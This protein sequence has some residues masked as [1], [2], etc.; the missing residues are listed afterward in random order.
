MTG[1]LLRRGFV[2]SCLMLLLVGA[3]A[4][5]QERQDPLDTVIG[6]PIASV[7]ITVEG[8]PDASTSLLLPL[9]D[10]KPNDALTVE[11][12]RRVE[13]RFNQVPRF[14]SISV[15]VDPRPGGLVLIF[16]LIPRHPVDALLVP[17][18]DD[19]GLPP[20]EIERRIRAEFNGIPALARRGDVE[21]T[22]KRI[23]REE[24][25][26]D[27]DAQASVV[28]RHN[29]D[30]STLEVRVVAGPRTT[31]ADAE[32]EGQ[33]PLDIARTRVRMGVTTG[34]P[35]RKAEIEKTLA[36]IRAELRTKKYYSAIAQLLD[37]QYSADGKTVTLVITIDAGPLVE[38]HVNGELPGRQDDLIPIKREASVDR[39]LLEDSARGIE[40]EWRKQGYRHAAAAFTDEHPSPDLQVITF[41]ITK[42]KRYHVDHVDLPKDDPL[43]NPVDFQTPKALQPGTLFDEKNV[44]AALSAIVRAYQAKG[45]PRVKM[46]R[47]FDEVPLA[48][49][50][51]EGIIIRPHLVEGPRAFVRKIDFQIQPGPGLQVPGVPKE[52]LQQLMK[53]KENQPYSLP[54]LDWD[55]SALPVF[56]VNQGYL[57]AKVSIRP[58]TSEDGT[59]VTLVVQAQEGPQVLVKEI[60]VV[61]NEKV[62]TET[63]M[64]QV[65]LQVGQPYSESKR[66]ETQ[67]ALYRTQQ[68]R[69]VRVTR[70]D[71]IPGEPSA[72]IVVAVEEAATKAYEFG[73]G[74]E[75]G[76]YPV[77]LS[78]GNLGDRTIFSP[79]GSVG[80]A[81]S[82]IGGRDR[83]F[84]AFAR[85]SLK[86]TTTQQTGTITPDYRTI[87]TYRERYAFHMKSDFLVSAVAEQGL[88]TTYNFIKRS[89][90]AEFLRPLSRT[91]NL[92]SRYTLEW[93]K[94]FDDVLDPNEQLTIDRLYPQV[95]IS[96]FSSGLGWDRRDDPIFTTHG[97]LVAVNGDLALKAFGSEVGFAKAFTEAS[98]F[99]TLIG[100]K[101]TILATRVQI[102]LARG[103][104]PNTPA[105]PNAPP[106]PNL[107]PF[108]DL[109]ASQRFFSGGSSTNRAFQ[110][111]RL[112]APNVLTADGLSTG[113]NGLVLFNLELRQHV[114]KLLK[115]D[116]TAVGF[117]DI[118]NVY[119]RVSEIDLSELRTGV[120]FGVRYDSWIGP[121]RFD[122]GYKTSQLT[123]SGGPERRWEFHLSI[124]EVF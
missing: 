29:P 33:S 113:G 82:N 59:N 40:A 83:T 119:R 122:V 84:N 15:K 36:Q 89:T 46:T 51:D 105:D 50:S 41:N 77:K 65:T 115:R 68:F 53:S 3:G 56:Y 73:G 88:R 45:Y 96:M 18:T 114:T 80:F 8:K 100:P 60:L 19:T 54:N 49:Q 44:D 5:A 26:L 62:S 9:I 7:E 98:W 108:R 37:T 6:Q 38:I 107:D 97:T 90:S 16:D 57:Q 12:L 58:E 43:I 11:A 111:D 34:S 104:D 27:A 121:L 72:R 110:L 79:R 87:A 22:V 74:V 93:S 55:R 1:T 112:G 116:V 92:S 64:R 109:P 102:G 81:K 10:I 21:D 76:N 120:G 28:Q 32:I 39:D 61:G 86:P 67:N 4:R 117:I 123:F 91:V 66:Y 31:I 95:R 17:P 35:F 13:D 52:A 20:A 106:D 85:L 14:E 75:A 94:R 69:S 71:T 42:G 70:D 103:F 63:I 118:G 23:M 30:R 24:G 25:F 99:R 124:G 101:K 2:M 78:D 48:N 47:D